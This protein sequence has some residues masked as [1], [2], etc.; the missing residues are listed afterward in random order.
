MEKRKLHQSFNNAIEGLIYAVKTQRNLRLHFL[1]AALIIFVS[2]YL[3][4]SR[5]EILIILGA[6][7]MVF[8]AEIFNT[9]VE[10]TINLISKE[11]NHMAKK[12]KDITAGAVFLVCIYAVVIGYL[13]F[14]PHFIFPIEDGLSAIKESPWHITFL[15]L[16]VVLSFVILGKAIFHRG[17]P[18][19]GGMPSG[20]SAVAFSI[21]TITFLSGSE[22]IVTMLVFM[23]AV[24]IALSR[25]K[26]A[27]HTAWEVV[28]GALLGIIITTLTFQFLR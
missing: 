26:Q 8:L 17:K 13:I 25:M 20:H 10:F 28:T 16:I 18:L 6:I 14:L 9:A 2:I 4:L 23:L 21:W 11:N 5:L 24:I 15:S 12:I 22:L 3:N 7:C 19:H 27:I 1:V